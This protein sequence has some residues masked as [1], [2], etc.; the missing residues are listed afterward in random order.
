MWMKSLQIKVDKV[1]LPG[2]L[3]FSRIDTSHTNALV[4]S[5][6]HD[7]RLFRNL[8]LETLSEDQESFEMIRLRIPGPLG[9]SFPGRLLILKQLYSPRYIL[10]IISCTTLITIEKNRLGFFFKRLTAERG[11]FERYLNYIGY[12]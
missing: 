3:G 11:Y 7:F 6:K 1:K 9:Y 4:Y 8:V 2:N 12:L 10:A 5:R